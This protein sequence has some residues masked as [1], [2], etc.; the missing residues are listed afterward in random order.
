MTPA[1][2]AGLSLS[3]LINMGAQCRHTVDTAD[4]S[5]LRHFVR[6][7]RCSDLLLLIEGEI[8][9]RALVSPDV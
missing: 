6:A 4:L 9:R 1:E 5:E 8:R 2:L 7:E 3:Q